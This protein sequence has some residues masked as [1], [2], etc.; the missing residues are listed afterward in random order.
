ML[1]WSP[2]GKYSGILKLSHV[3]ILFLF[4]EE[5]NSVL[6]SRE[7]GGLCLYIIYLSESALM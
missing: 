3:V 2:L 4:Y 1:T 7:I 5:L 6:Y